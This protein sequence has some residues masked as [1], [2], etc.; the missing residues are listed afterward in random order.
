MQENEKRHDMPLLA[1]GCLFEDFVRRL[2]PK[3]P[4]ADRRRAVGPGSRAI[5][6][7]IAGT[8]VVATCGRALVH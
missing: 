8:F 4:G 7:V 2:D 1:D 3:D 5:A 6:E